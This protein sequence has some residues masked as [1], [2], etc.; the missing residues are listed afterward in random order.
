M[1]A[2]R[3]KRYQITEEKIGEDTLRLLKGRPRNL[4]ELLQK[5]V[6]ESP[7][8]EGLVSGDRRWT[9]GHFG[10]KVAR[11]S[12]A[13]Q[14][15][16]GAKKG[17]RIAIFM[18]T[19]IEY[20]L[21]FFG[22]TS[23]GGI[24]VPLNNRFSGE[25]LLYEIRNSESSILIMDQSFWEILG[26]LRNQLVSVKYLFVRG[27][28]TPRGT[29]P[30]SALLDEPGEKPV[31]VELREED[32]AMLMYTS[33]T[34]GFPKGA[35]QTHR[36]IILACML[37]DDI[38]E[39]KPETDRML[40]VLPMFHAAGTIMSSFAAIY[41]KVPC[42]Y[43]S[44]FKTEKVLEVI[45]RERISLMVHVPTIY[46]LLANHSDFDRYD[47][48]SFRVGITGGAPKSKETFEVLRN[49]LPWARFVDTFGLTETHTLDFI[50]DHEEMTTQMSAVG[51]VVPIEEVRIEDKEGNFCAPGTPGEIL[52]KGPKI[53]LGYWNN[54]QGTKEAIRDGWF[55]TGD[56]GKIDE[57]GY[58]YILDRIKDMINRGGENIY[59]VEV[60]NA[61]SRN[62]KVAETAVIGVPD[63][64]FGE[65]VKAYVILRKGATMTED[66]LQEHCKRYLADYKIP[67]YVEFVDDLPRNQTG[68]IMKKELRASHAI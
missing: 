59:S 10:D 35:M 52:I 8:K 15:Q 51:R 68:K 19:D 67:K 25:E 63:K 58:V 5:T 14:N 48:K 33:G 45:Q 38:F 1:T 27:S 9:F 62:P 55:H 20:P 3:L 16:F 60:E 57:S 2:Y 30:F 44:K 46:W 49:R 50:L 29:L 36:G 28:E 40:N 43:M 26:P 24:A 61:I 34:T 47:L 23:F 32:V 54:P 39:S 4:A 64:V 56:F 7:Q 65:V 11:L 42:V 6:T 41:M 18:E 17:D 37:I 22:I 13:L 53:V 31:L 66:E 21:T 12:W